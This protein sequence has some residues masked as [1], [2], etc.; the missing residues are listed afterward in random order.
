MQVIDVAVIDSSFTGHRRNC[1]KDFV[2]MSHKKQN[3]DLFCISQK[4]E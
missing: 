2:Y 3:E 4:K 1:S